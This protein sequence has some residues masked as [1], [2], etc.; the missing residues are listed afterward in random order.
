MVRLELECMVVKKF[1][2][3]TAVLCNVSEYSGE[4]VVHRDYVTWLHE[5]TADYVLSCA[6]LVNREKIFLSE[7]VFYCLLKA[8][9]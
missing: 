3:L 9:E 2:D 8:L 1:L 6:A 4:V 5:C 7:Y